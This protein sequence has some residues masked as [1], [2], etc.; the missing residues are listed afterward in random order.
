[1]LGQ[2]PLADARLVVEAVERGFGGDLHQVAIAFFVFGEH[3]QVVVG[4]TFRRGALDVVVVFLADVE[5]ASDDGLDPDFVGGIDEMHRAKD[6]AMVGHGHGR[7]AEFFD[8]MDQLL[9]VAS[10]I[11]Q[12]VVAVQVQVD[13]FGHEDRVA[14]F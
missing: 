6:I 2:K 1:M 12:R 7:H 5:L 14:S 4:V 3:E 8:A 11:E 13:E 9:D 10:A